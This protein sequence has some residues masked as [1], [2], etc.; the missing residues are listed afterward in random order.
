MQLLFPY[1]LWLRPCTTQQQKDFFSWRPKGHLLLP[2]AQDAAI[3][4]EETVLADHY[5]AFCCAGRMK[6]H[7]S[8]LE[9]HWNCSLCLVFLCVCMG[10]K[11]RQHTGSSQ[12]LFLSVGMERPWLVLTVEKCF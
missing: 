11:E 12:Y 8:A 10:G 3:L 4:W 6:P 7:Y 9:S 1:S 2:A 5:P